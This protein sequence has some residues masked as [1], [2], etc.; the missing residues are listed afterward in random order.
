[1]WEKIKL[2]WAGIKPDL[3]KLLKA[4]IKLSID[5]LL[6]IAI[7]AVTQAQVKGESGEEKFKYACD[8]V[9]AQAPKAAI[10]AV[11]TAVQSAWA[12]KEAE[13]W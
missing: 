2:I 12:Q 13:G 10:G 8:Y 1:M 7:E 9:K 5:V 3:I 4:L 6:P 11:Q